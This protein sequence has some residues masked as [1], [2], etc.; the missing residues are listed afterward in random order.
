LPD[1]Q[2]G[3]AGLSNKPHCITSQDIFHLHAHH[4]GVAVGEVKENKAQKV[5]QCSFGTRILIHWYSLMH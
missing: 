4:Q 3:Q 1:G 5:N 2:K